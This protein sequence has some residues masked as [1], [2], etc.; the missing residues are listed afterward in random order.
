LDTES[1]LLKYD[2]SNLSPVESAGLRDW[3][4][5]PDQ[6]AV[7]I[8]SRPSRPPAGVFSTPEA[9]QGAALVGLGEIPIL[10]WGGLVWL[11]QQRQTDPQTFL[12]PSP[13]HALAAL[14]MALGEDQQTA[15][16]TAANLVE[17]GQ[18]DTAWKQLDGAKVSVFEDTPG[19]IKSMKAAKDVLEKVGVRTKTQYYGIAQKSIKVKALQGNGAQVFPSLAE[20]LA[21]FKDKLPE[22]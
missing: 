10:G 7:V 16:S 13:V 8:T 6:A 3:M 5:R 11:G 4:S 2:R 17:N 9:E 15:L 20:T 21:D 12:K 19:G 1:Y 14:R 22:S 18:V